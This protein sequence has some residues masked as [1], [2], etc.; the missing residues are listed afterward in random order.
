[1]I[2]NCN[3]QE[4]SVLYKLMTSIIVPRPIGWI[5]TLSKDNVDNIAPFS[6]FNM[7]AH[8]PPHVV[9]SPVIINNKRKDT[10]QNII[11]TKEFV[12][13]IVTRELAEIMNKTAVELPI[14]ESEF[15]F[16]EIETSPSVYVKAKRVKASPIQLECKLKL[17]HT[18][19]GNNQGGASLIVGEVLAIH[20]NDEIV[21]ENLKIDR[22]KYQPVGKLSGGLYTTLSE[23]FYIRR[24]VKKE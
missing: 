8:D 13:N 21:D 14:D 23:E 12:V 20:I 11:D 4:G 18:I 19:E 24:V 17:H 16:A 6:F 1:M 9:V 15:D 2:V 5:S 3:K 22:N 7:V 10:A